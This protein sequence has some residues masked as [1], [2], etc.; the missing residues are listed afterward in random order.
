[1]QHLEVI[2]RRRW[3][4]YCVALL[5]TSIL[6]GITTAG[7]IAVST[8]YPSALQDTLRGH[9]GGVIC[10]AFSSDGQTMATGGED[11]T[12]RLWNLASRGE[13]L[14]LTGHMNNVVAVAFSPDNRLVASASWDGSVRVWD[15]GTGQQRTALVGHPRRNRN[16]KPAPVFDVAFSPDGNLLA[17]GGADETM[18]LWEV[19]TG[20]QL[21]V[22]QHSD[23]ISCVLFNADGKMLVSRTYS[24]VISVWDLEGNQLR[25]FGERH[26]RDRI[27]QLRLGPDGTTL[28]SNG[29]SQPKVT[30][31]DLATGAE[32]AFLKANLSFQNSPVNCMAFYPDGKVL[33]ATT[34]FGARLLV[35][36]MHTGQLL[37]NV[38]FPRAFSIAFSPDGKTLAS[39]HEDG[40]VKLWDSTKLMSIK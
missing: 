29:S 27:F 34:M 10:V 24:G 35:W 39:V 38:H 16:G 31:W 22:C 13:Q 14:I 18:W 2:H 9:Q 28:A 37:N 21:A 3:P 25:R 40:T 5:V 26:I 11:R 33:T 36:D 8:C 6:L 12:V 20:K 30:L 19:A 23:D 7:W 17:S 15:T 1:M 4:R 32:L